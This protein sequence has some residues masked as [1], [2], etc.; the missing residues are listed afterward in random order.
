MACDIT[1]PSSVAELV[2][3]IV[4]VRQ[5]SLSVIHTAGISPS[6]GDA[7]RIMRINAIGT[8][9][10]NEGFRG[11]AGEGF[12]LVNVASMA[13]HMLPESLIP[14][15]WFGYAAQDEDKFMAKMMSACNIAP[16][17][18]RSD[19]AYCLSKSFVV[20]YTKSQAMAFGRRGARIVSVS[21]GTIDT[22]MGR[23]EE[24]SGAAMLRFAALKR[25]GR[26]DEVAELLAFCASDKPGYLTGVDILCDGGNMASMTLRDKLAVTRNR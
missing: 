24:K 23:L 12:A 22:S 2:E 9:N 13:A 18:I 16:K 25:L 26:P 7:D 5:L 11:V 20:W 14:T 21:P 4:S 15:K 3:G 1:D 6:M 19:M 10:V 17:K 8:L